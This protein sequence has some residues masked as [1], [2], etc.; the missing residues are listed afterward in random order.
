MASEQFWE[1]TISIAIIGGLILTIWAKI[2]KQTIG[3]LIRD[4]RDSFSDTGEETTEAM[5]WNE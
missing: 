5:V 4:L 2:S 3:E 1:W